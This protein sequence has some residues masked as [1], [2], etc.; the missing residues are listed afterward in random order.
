MSKLSGYSDGCI[1]RQVGR[2]AILA[3]A[4]R[5]GARNVRVFG[6][7]ARGE[8]GDLS[9]LDRL[10]DPERG[11]TPMDPGGFLMDLQN[12]LRMRVDV[13]TEGMLR[14]EPGQRL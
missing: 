13:T 3:T 1:L 2:D 11:R 7:V 8:A 14:P 10:V 4:M 9:D 12:Q 5:Y 6:S